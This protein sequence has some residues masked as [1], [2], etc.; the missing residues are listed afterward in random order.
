MCD[1]TTT[2]CKSRFG[3]EVS[4]SISRSV[5]INW[6]GKKKDPKS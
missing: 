1:D 3:S 6:L 5:G 2:Q 4:R